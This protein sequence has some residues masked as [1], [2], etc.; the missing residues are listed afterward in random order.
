MKHWTNTLS[1]TAAVA[2]TLLGAACGG[3]ETGSIEPGATAYAVEPT[4]ILPSSAQLLALGEQTYQK[5]CLACHGAEGNG[6]GE[7]A[8][9]LYPRPRD[10]TAARYRLVSTWDT[11]PTDE[12]LFR[13]IS[14]GMPGSGMPSW[15]HLPEETRWGLVHHIKGFASRDLTVQ[16][17][18]DPPSF[19][20]SGTGMIRVPPE[21]P[22]DD[23]ARA[24]AD[25]LYV[26]GCAPCHGDTGKGDGPQDQVDSEGY[27][28]RPRDLTA[29]VYKGSPEPE[30]L[31][32]RIVAGL[33]GS[34][35]PQSAY[36]D[37]DDAWHL[38]HLVR[39]MSSD[40]QRAKVEM[41]RF[42]IVAER[43][44]ALPTHPDDGVWGEAL[45]VNLHLM[46]LWWRDDRP[47]E[48][49]VK[50]LHD[51]T[52]IA[53]RLRWFDDTNDTTA[54]RPQDFRDAA[55]VQ[56]ALADDPPFFAMGQADSPVNIWMWKSERQADL[57]LAFQDLE[58]IYPNTGI[59][60]YPNPFISPLE[61]PMRHALTLESDPRFVTGWGAGNIV[62]D[63]TRRSAAEDLR[64]GGFGTLRARPL[65]DQDVSA[66]G[67]Y[68]IGSYEVVFTR[69]MNPGGTDAAVLSPGSATTVSFAVWDGS[70]GD[71]DGKKS[72]TIWQDL[73]IQP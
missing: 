24:R 4:E 36:L 2:L 14:R 73:V 70:A 29:G 48:L 61:Q 63:P 49:N 26:M 55:A 9:L 30:E 42:Q 20:A 33:P 40:E 22:Y 18:S 6:E 13:A 8:Y 37:G 17:D 16:P 58:R 11:V 15:A 47:E 19:G 5:Q 7:A 54:I 31:Y 52:R 57:D 51:G 45:A 34:P 44:T 27:A 71:R 10:F 65:T 62:S 41:R 23:D 46:P 32:R 39:G 67:H 59:D 1:T 56:F 38:V 12:D 28:T 50:A 35:M 72:V 66:L 68:E 43:V 21:P 64:A 60:S 53:L 69:P 25:E 3:G